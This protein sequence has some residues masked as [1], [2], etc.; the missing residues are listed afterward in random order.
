MTK[1]DF[2]AQL[3]QELKRRG[4][5][6][7][8][9]VLEEYEQHFAFKLSDGYSEEEIAAKLGSPKELAAQFDPAPQKKSGASREL[10]SLRRVLR[11]RLRALGDA[12]WADRILARMGLVR[13]RDVSLLCATQ[14]RMPS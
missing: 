5:A 11:A 2:M 6:D 12:G 1:L 14:G 4:V 8:D 7:A 9:D 10:R 13:P 3:E